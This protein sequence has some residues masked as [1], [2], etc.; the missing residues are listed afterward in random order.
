VV[1]AVVVAEPSHDLAQVID[2]ERHRRCV[3]TW[4]MTGSARTSVAVETMQATITT[5]RMLSAP[6]RSMSLAVPGR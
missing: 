1:V 3:P 5:T 2:S 4:K 6:R